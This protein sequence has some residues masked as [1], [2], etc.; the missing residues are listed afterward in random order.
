MPAPTARAVAADDAPPRPPAD[1]DRG[2]IL[3]RNVDRL[4]RHLPDPLLRACYDLLA[5]VRIAHAVRVPRHRAVPSSVPA[6]AA[7]Q[8]EPVADL[9]GLALPAVLEAEACGGGA[10]TAMARS[11]ARACGDGVAPAAVHER[12]RAVLSLSFTAPAHF[13]RLAALYEATRSGYVARLRQ[14]PDGPESYDWLSRDAQAAALRVLRAYVPDA[15]RA[16]FEVVMELTLRWPLTTNPA[17]PEPPSADE[18]ASVR[19]KRRRART[20]PLPSR[21]SSTCSHPTPCWRSSAPRASR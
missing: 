1:D 12:V 7:G 16:A 18:E 21:A 13:L 19:R 14:L 17:L 5:P 2:P 10:H 9:T 6:Q 3:T 8:S 11:L 4:V 15:A 20:A